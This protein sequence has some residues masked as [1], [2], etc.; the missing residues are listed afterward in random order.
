MDSVSIGLDIGSS[1]VRAAE[2]SQSQGKRVLRRYAQ[3][4]LP[5]GYVADGTIV[6]IPGV[7]SALR[8]LWTEGGFVSNKVVLGVSGPRVIVRQADMPALSA[9]EIRSALK[10]DSQELIPIPMEDA[11]FDFTVLD[12]APRVDSDGRPTTRIL[13][14]AAHNDLVRGHMAA[15]KGAGL[16]AVAIDAAPLAL[17]RVVPPGGPSGSPSGLEVLV[18]IGAELTTIA[19]REDGTPRFI[20]SLAVGGAKLTESLANTMHLDMAAAESL[21][22]GKIPPGA[23][24]MAQARKAM[25]VEMRDLAE[26]VR[27]TVDFFL[28]QSGRTE[29]DRMLVTGGASQTEGL[30][31]AIAGSQAL[32][33]SQIDPF[34]GLSIGDV[35]LTQ[36]QMKAASSTAA[37]AI[38]LALWTSESPSARLSVLPD[39][40]TAARR[41]RRLM[42]AAVAAVAGLSALLAVVAVGETVVVHRAQS[43]VTAAN[44]QV[45]SLQHQVTAKQAA[46]AVHGEVQARTSLVVESLK[47]DVDWVRV[48]G[49]LASVMP[50]DVSLASFSGTRTAQSAATP[51]STSASQST[52][53]S[54]Q[55]NQAPAVGT[56][57]FSVQGSGGMASVSAWLRGLER[58]PALQGTWVTGISTT[59]NNQ[60]QVTFSSTANLTPLAQSK[61]AQGV[62][63]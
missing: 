18:S 9:E 26:D 34:A 16:A 3:I 1:A 10:F 53:S 58:Y 12:P 56:I 52:G 55:A 36:S 60:L 28:S 44:K 41:A 51:Q 13:V 21:K 2:I 14:V 30:A 15:L 63:P 39:E 46:T 27:G 8:R 42:A 7:S 43:Q 49:Q 19:V 50:P 11:S 17:M 48:L 32:T 25:S 31:A 45:A 20:R 23:P 24:Q 29:I 4:G 5:P 40:V 57:A 33:I 22:R 54:G 37:A 59:G 62:K 6:N 61:R 35:D 38:G 47:G